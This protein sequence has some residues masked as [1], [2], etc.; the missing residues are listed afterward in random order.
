MKALAWTSPI[1]PGAKPLSRVRWPLPAI[2]APT[3]AREPEL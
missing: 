2:P 1:M 3:P